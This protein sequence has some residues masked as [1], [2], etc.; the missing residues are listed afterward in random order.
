MNKKYELI[1]HKNTKDIGG[2]VCDVVEYEQKV[3][4]TP[5]YLEDGTN[6]VFT[7]EGSD[8]VFIRQVETT[9]GVKLSKEH[10]YVLRIK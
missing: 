8:E 2:R 3:E 10:T 1:L 9:F 5:L 7:L 4:T 6:D